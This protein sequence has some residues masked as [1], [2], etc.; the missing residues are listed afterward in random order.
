M[1]SGSAASVHSA[2]VGEVLNDA[3]ASFRVH[4]LENPDSDAE[5]LMMSLLR[6]SRSALYMHPGQDLSPDQA[7]AYRSFV[8]RRNAGEPPQYIVGEADF[9]GRTFLVNPSVLIPRPETEILLNEAISISSEFK[10]PAILDIGTG[11][12]NIAVTLAKEIPNADVRGIDN[13]VEAI[14]VAKENKNRH[15]CKNLSLSQIDILHEYPEGLY[16][17]VVSNPPYIAAGE[18]EELMTDVKNFEP[19]FS[20]TDDSDGLTFYKRMASI[21]GKLLTPGGWII[22][23]VGGGDHSKKVFD[24]FESADFKH[25]ELVKDYNG[26]ARVMKAEY[27]G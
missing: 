15:G 14:A 3:I 6:C 2:R 19:K 11:S 4:G 23:E 7:N 22:L 1:K 17:M 20:L 9:F 13:A 12:G 21:P 24:I 16:H 5:W 18:M 10:N 27:C 25:C 26:D 8:R